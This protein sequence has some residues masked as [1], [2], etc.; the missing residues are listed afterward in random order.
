MGGLLGDDDRPGAGLIVAHVVND[1]LGVRIG[2]DR[3]QF[4]DGGRLGR[5]QKSTGVFVA[6]AV[7]HAP[8]VVGDV[9]GDVAGP[10]GIEFVGR[11]V[12]EDDRVVL[13]EVLRLGRQFGD[14]GVAVPN[15]HTRGLWRVSNFAI[16]DEKN[17]LGWIPANSLRE[18]PR[19][20]LGRAHF[21]LLLTKMVF[22]FP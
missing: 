7:E 9:A 16:G 14:D 15:G 11:G 2:D 4:D 6:G 22:M 3:Q 21:L 5:S 8:G 12:E 17:K 19:R 13:A 10:G 18:C 1:D 20:K